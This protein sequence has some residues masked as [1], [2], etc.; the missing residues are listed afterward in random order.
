MASRDS[1]AIARVLVIFPGALGDL[2]CAGPAI[3]EIARRHRDAKIELMAKAELARF[4]PGR[5]PIAHG[6][7]IDRREVAALFSDGDE[8]ASEAREFFGAFERI[9]SFFAS[10]DARFRRMLE[11]CATVVGAGGDARRHSRESGRVMFLPFRPEGQG[12]VAA[13]YLHALGIENAAPEFRLT[14]LSEDVIR[15]RRALEAVEIRP[16]ADFVVI[17]PGSG[18]RSKNWSAANY[19]EFIG[20]LL[21]TIQVAVVLGP[22]EEEG[23]FDFPGVPTLGNLELSVVAGIA[24]LAIGFV[25]ND[26]GVSHLA[27]ATGTP[28]VVIFGPTSPDRWR[29]LG[30]IAV[31]ARG[32]LASI[33]PAEVCA[34]IRALVARRGGSLAY[35]TVVR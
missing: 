14:P 29:P 33:T 20:A 1:P 26:S 21:P 31:I 5:M 32:N 10:G 13:G 11:Q 35:Q 25:G 28:G 19:R 6:H 24:R 2:I 15:A 30:D 7:S 8:P 3:A 22:A 16:D 12:H 9:Y 18:S 17:F 4:A 23:D 27:A 34:S